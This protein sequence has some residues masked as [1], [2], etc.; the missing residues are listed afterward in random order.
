MESVTRNMY[1]IQYTPAC[2]CRA[3]ARASDGSIQGYT[4]FRFRFRLSNPSP[5]PFHLRRRSDYIVEYMEKRKYYCDCKQMCDGVQREV[6]KSTYYSHRPYR[7]ALSKFTPGLR[8]F[9]NSIP[10]TTH[11][12]SSCATQSSQHARVDGPSNE[13]TDHV[14]GPP[15]KRA[16][17]PGD[18]PSH[19]V[20]SSSWKCTV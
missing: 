13:T 6:G 16:R 12:P 8:T 18:G 10:T 5:C 1:V 14:V 7:D 9:L 20:G 4:C 11:T 2:N 17:Q 19:A 15:Y 3:R